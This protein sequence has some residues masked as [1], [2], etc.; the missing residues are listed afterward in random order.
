MLNCPRFA[1][2]S[3]L[4]SAAQ[5]SPPMRRGEKGNAVR[6]L[7]Q[8]LVEMPASFRAGDFDGIFGSETES[9]LRKFQMQRGLAADGIAGRQTF[10]TMMKTTA[11]PGIV[12][13]NFISKVTK[14]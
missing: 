11:R 7:Q 14:A 8:A 10:N 4:I 3:R 13:P 5:N 9:V 6:I 1:P 12:L 2:H